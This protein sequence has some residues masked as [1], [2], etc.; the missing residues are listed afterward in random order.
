MGACSFTDVAYAKTANEAFKKCVDEAIYENGN[1]S[2]SGTIKEKDDFV[3][4]TLPKGKK[5]DSFID[6]KIGDNN[7]WGPA[8]C[9]QVD[10]QAQTI[11]QEVAAG[12][13]V[14][15][16]PYK[17]TRKWE[18]VYT[19]RPTPL[20][21]Y[22]GESDEIIPEKSF[23]YKAEAIAHARKLAEKHNK[24]FEVFIE[25]KLVGSEAVV[26]Q[27]MPKTKKEKVKLSKFIF[28][29]MASC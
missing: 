20:H 1:G 4:V 5:L 3:M 15:N 27:I 14:E 21:F 12:S 11:E 22:R 10:K 26:A 24:D 8:Y 28:F 19:V 17:G 6:E 25:K 18:M 2:Y 7:K 16:K 29:G 9:I 23:K 13:R